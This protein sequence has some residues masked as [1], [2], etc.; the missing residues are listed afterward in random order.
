VT[1]SV[2]PFARKVLHLRKHIVNKLAPPRKT[3][4]GKSDFRRQKRGSESIWSH[5]L[6]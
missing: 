1:Y 4:K 2:K 3:A 5:T 6:S